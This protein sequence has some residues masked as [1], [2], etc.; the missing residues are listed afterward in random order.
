MLEGAPRQ[1][2]WLGAGAYLA[3]LL[4]L[5][6]TPAPPDDPQAQGPFWVNVR[7]FDTIGRSLSGQMGSAGRL[8]LLGNVAAFV[9]VGFLVP[10]LGRPSWRAVAAAGFGLSVAIETTQL[11]LSLLVG[12]AYRHADV[13]DV[14]LNGSGALAGYLG[15]LLLRGLLRGAER[16][17]PA[18]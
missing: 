10:L 17:T 15:F 13:D 14:I 9:P 6:L 12:Q 16:Q 2:A 5:T 18:V 11:S 8:L 7:P 4:A 3:V 1:L